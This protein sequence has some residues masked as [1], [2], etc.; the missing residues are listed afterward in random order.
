M[1]KS[2]STNKKLKDFDLVEK[3][4]AELA[5][6]IFDVDKTTLTV[7]IICT[8]KGKRNKFCNPSFG[9]TFKRGFTK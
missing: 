5:R 8:V 9:M 1:K 2:N 7:S 3:Q 6:L 4:A